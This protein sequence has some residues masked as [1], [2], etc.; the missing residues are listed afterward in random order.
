[1]RLTRMHPRPVAGSERG[2][3]LVEF[4][5]VALFLFSLSMGMIEYGLSYQGQERVLGASRTG[6]RTTASL[7]TDVEADYQAL[8]S[9]RADLLAS[10]MLGQIEAV[11]I[12]KSATTDGMPPAAC[13]TSPPAATTQLCNIFTQAQIQNLNK[14]TFSTT[15]GCSTT[16][17]SISSRWCPNIRNDN[18]LSAD[19]VGMY[20]R[21]RHP[22]ITKFYGSGMAIS[23]RSVMRIE[24]SGG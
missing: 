4:A 20:V 1:M 9:L 21:I 19:Y 10:D 8:T 15:T 16:V 3:A 23:Q 13:M 24:P 18:Q 12:Y 22:F 2:V 14:A 17:G 7:G 5:L 11:V 6:V